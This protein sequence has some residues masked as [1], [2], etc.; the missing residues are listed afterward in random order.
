[1]APNSN[2]VKFFGNAS[3]AT[4]YTASVTVNV[5]PVNG[6]IISSMTGFALNPANSPPGTTSVTFGT[7]QNPLSAGQYQNGDY[8]VW[9]VLRLDVTGSSTTF[10][11][12]QFT[13]V[14]IAMAGNRAIKPPVAGVTAGAGAAGGR[15]TVSAVVSGSN[16]GDG[17]KY[18]GN[19]Q[20]YVVSQS[21]AGPPPVIGPGLALNGNGPPNDQG[22]ANITVPSVPAGTYVVLGVIA[23]TSST[24]DQLVL[25]PPV[26]GISVK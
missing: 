16:L 13:K 15:G 21:S 7:A 10:V 11:Y 2:E 12:S 18:N 24:G 20:V 6:G 23:I 14:T 19:F 1:V 5:A 9:G 8:Y 4:G 17:W 26:T 22:V 25:A 3:W